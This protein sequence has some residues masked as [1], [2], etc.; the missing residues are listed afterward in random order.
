MLARQIV[1][2][3]SKECIQ[4]SIH[5]RVY[6]SRSISRLFDPVNLMF[7]SS[8]VSRRSIVNSTTETASSNVPWQTPSS[9]ELGPIVRVIASELSIACKVNDSNNRLWT[10][11]AKNVAKTVR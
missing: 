8:K 5:Y 3:F 9:E 1:L 6:L 2:L 7:A 10:A 4:H 11:V